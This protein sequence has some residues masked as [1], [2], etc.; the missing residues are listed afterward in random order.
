MYLQ[1]QLLRKQKFIFI[2]IPLNSSLAR[3]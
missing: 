3:F 2:S 1:L